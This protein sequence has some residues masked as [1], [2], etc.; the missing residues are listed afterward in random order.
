MCFA[1]FVVLMIGLLIWISILLIPWRPWS[2]IESIDSCIDHNATDLSDITVLIPARNEASTIN[3]TLSALKKQSANLKIIV[4]DDQSTDSTLESIEKTNIKNLLIVNG[5]KPPEG[6]SGK[7]WALQ[8]GLKRVK[9]KYLILLDADIVVDEAIIASTINK[10]KK[11][12]LNMLSIMVFLNMRNFWERLL[13]PAFI[14]FFKLLYPFNLAN[15]PNSK[16][17]AAAGGFILLE[18]SMLHEL[19]GFNSIRN[20]LIDD[21]ALAKKI[22]Q[23]GYKTWTGLSHSICSIRNYTTLSSIWEMVARTAYTQLF[24]SPW[25]LLLCTFLMLSTFV[26]P[27]L[28]ILQFSKPMIVAIGLIITCIQIACYTPTL[29]YYFIPYGYSLLL[30]LIALLYLIMTWDSAYKY[31]FKQGALWKD[32]HYN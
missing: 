1:L 16:V 19:D 18:T 32:R 17:A 12:K 23:K 27:F 15:K 3:Q 11:E 4:V 29:R 14:F 6:W 22:K 8:Q 5:I 9:T 21:C 10:L 25:L 7:L 28:A 13:M 31:Y 24:Y 30:P 20:A 2:T 26:L